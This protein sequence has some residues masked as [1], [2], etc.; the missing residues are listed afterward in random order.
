MAP[1]L[2]ARVTTASCALALCG[3]FLVTDFEPVATSGTGGTGSST[4]VTDA[5]ADASSASQSGA[6]GGGEKPCPTGLDANGPVLARFDFATKNGGLIAI[7][8][9]PEG[10]VMFT[11]T[12]PGTAT[13]WVSTTP[14]DLPD[15]FAGSLSTDG[16]LTIIPMGRPVIAGLAVA[17]SRIG[18][19]DVNDIS[20]ELRIFDS[21]LLEPE[22][23]LDFGCNHAGSSIS[24][25]SLDADDSDF[26]VAFRAKK[27]TSMPIVCDSASTLENLDTGQVAI[28]EPALASLLAIPQVPYALENGSARI[29]NGGASVCLITGQASSTHCAFRAGSSWTYGDPFTTFDIPFVAPVRHTALGALTRLSEPGLPEDLYLALASDPSTNFLASPQSQGGS[30]AF[31]GDAAYVA[32]AGF[33][34]TSLPG[35]SSRANVLTLRMDGSLKQLVLHGD[36]DSKAI[37]AFVRQQRLIVGGNYT[38][39]IAVGCLGLDAPIASAGSFIGLLPLPT[40]AYGDAQ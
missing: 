2:C 28:F 20:F 16:K 27:T 40:S 32:V 9:G 34:Q 33:L 12:G 23:E 5:S 19:I 31:Y 4:S 8:P 25:V 36:G 26:T 24:S 17:G 18:I 39:N 10:F 21:P 13:S 15:A 6:G 14:I 22:N 3:C 11:G 35:A 38:A 37:G 29:G 1:W 7:E 30:L